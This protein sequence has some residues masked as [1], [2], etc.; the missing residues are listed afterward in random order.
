MN[1]ANRVSLLVVAT[2]L[3]CIPAYAAP[4]PVT[5]VQPVGFS[6]IPEKAT[7]VVS[8]GSEVV[9]VVPAVIVVQEGAPTVMVVGRATLPIEGGPYTALFTVYS[10]TG[11]L[12]SATREIKD[13]RLEAA[14]LLEVSELKRRLTEQK[15]ELRKWDV[16]ATEQKSKLKKVQEQADTLA[17]V[18]RIVDAD[19]E[20]RT[21][22]DENHRLTAS[23]TLAQERQL[24]LKTREAPPN[25]K[26]RDAELSAQ[27]NVL[28]TELKASEN[29]EDLASGSKELQEKEALIESTK[30]EHL[31]L[32]KDE[33]AKLRRQ[34]EALE[35]SAAA[36]N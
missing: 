23:I 13:V 16:Q 30:Y 34:R 18:S 20:L 19:D 24:A 35:K 15:T 4:A 29:D 33:L 11:D 7:V 2:T 27:L 1:F 6:A 22:K 21:A 9:A 25:Y 3:F 26:K 12:G 17:S 36:G 5:L 31:D 10:K 28:A 8:Q 32:L 14:V